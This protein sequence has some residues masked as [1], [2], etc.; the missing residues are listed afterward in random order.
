MN[1]LVKR[2]KS[3]TKELKK[4]FA[5]QISD[6]RLEYIMN[7]QNSAVKKIRKLAKDIKRHFT[8]ECGK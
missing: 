4:M 8:E 5:N 3:Q 2:M 7:S 6:K 1:A